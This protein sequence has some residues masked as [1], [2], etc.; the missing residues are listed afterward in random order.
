MNLH[1][2]SEKTIKTKRTYE[3]SIDDKGDTL[4]LLTHR[5]NYSRG[6]SLIVETF[7]SGGVETS[8]TLY[9]YE[10][11]KLFKSY[12]YLTGN[13]SIPWRIDS[14]IRKEENN[15]HYTFNYYFE[16]TKT[17]SSGQM[18]DETIEEL[19]TSGNVILKVNVI[20]KWEYD[21]VNCEFFEYDTLNRVT[22]KVT[23]YHCEDMRW[24]FE[25]NK[26]DN[27]KSG[28][29]KK[30][31]FEEKRVKSSAQY[32]EFEYDNQ[33]RLTRKKSHSLDLTFTYSEDE[34]I[35]IEKGNK[36]YDVY[37]RYNENDDL[38]ERYQLKK[39]DA[40]KYDWQKYD[41]MY[42]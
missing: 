19:D 27:E 17:F 28:K 36:G 6:G 1:S 35:V 38:I 34:K 37:Y 21:K 16:T 41:Y 39:G 42:F 15:I 25:S 29:S 7:F 3:V 10:K 30:N 11:Q 20:D 40:K 12:S 13:D 5:E 4:Y 24:N 2:Q 32:V 31:Y 22:K 23:V 18:R 33:N 14:I 8:K 26:N 9:F